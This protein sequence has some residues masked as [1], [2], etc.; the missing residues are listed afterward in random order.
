MQHVLLST[1]PKIQLIH[2]KGKKYQLLNK[3][4]PPFADDGNEISSGYG[5]RRIETKGGFRCQ[6]GVG[7]VPES[8]SGRV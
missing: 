2:F 8:I 5:I 6:L 4:K 7:R 3:K 1:T